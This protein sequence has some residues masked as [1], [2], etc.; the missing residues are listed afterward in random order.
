MTKLLSLT[1]LLAALAL[2]TLA[3]AQP[4]YVDDR[5]TP[6]AV[7][8]SFYNAINRQEYARAWSYYEDGQGVPAF[9]AFTAGYQS[10]KSVTLTLGK[11][12]SDGAAG[13][14][15]YSLPASIDALST[16]GK[17]AYFAGCYT[18]RL[19]NPAIQAEPPFQPMHI[20][21]GHLSK[22]K[23]AGKSFLPTNCGQ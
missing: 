8:Q 18:L 19:A 22:A 9:D 3:Q 14:T 7:I 12:T 10:T 16:A 20:T 4:A 17:H 2:P 23:D 21:D 15:Y 11:P 6:Q 13:S 5:S 1:I